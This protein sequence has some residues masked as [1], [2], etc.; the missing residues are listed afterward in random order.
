MIE[1][2]V[3][4]YLEADAALK[5]LLGGTTADSKIYPLVAQLESAAPF[6][7]YTPT[8]DDS[9]DENVDE[10]RIQLTIAGDTKAI[11]D[12]IR[13]RLNVLLDK[14]DAIQ[15]T[16]LTSSTYYIYWCKRTGGDALYDPVR[17]LKNVVLFFTLRYKKK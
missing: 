7:V 6:I 16:S 10:D 8:F 1:K 11:C 15:H 12:G 9:G 2:D 17:G 14:Q 3:A 5:T 4:L 13:D